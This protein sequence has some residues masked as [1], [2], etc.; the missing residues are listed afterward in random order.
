[1]ETA[2]RLQEW[3]WTEWHGRYTVERTDFKSVPYQRYPR[4]PIPPPGVEL[5]KSGEWLVSPSYAYGDDNLG[6]L[7]AVNLFLE[8]FGQAEVLEA[9]GRRPVERH[10]RLHWEILPRGQY[11]WERLKERL[12]SVLRNQQNQ[13]AHLYRLETVAS[14]EPNFT[15]VGRAGFR[16]YF[17]FGFTEEGLYVLESAYPG[18]ATY[19]LGHDWEELSKLTKAEILSDQLHEDRIIHDHRWRRAIRNLLGHRQQ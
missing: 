12:E 15:A 13:P 10:R 5:I 3:S 17:I 1:M 19:V 11:P 2:Y 9:E 6:L 16:G 7:H 8:I 14:Y 4:T 18:N